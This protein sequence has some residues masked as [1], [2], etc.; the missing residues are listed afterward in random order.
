MD[1]IGVAIIGSGYW[2]INYVRSMSELPNIESVTVCEQRIDRLEEI[3]HKFPKAGLTT[4][5]DEVL[6][7]PDIGA[8]VICTPA[9]THYEV[10]RRCLTAG[11][12]VLVEKPIT[13]RSIDAEKL[14]GTAEE[15]DVTLMVGHTFIH[16]PAIRKLKTFLEEGDVGQPYYIYS[17]RTNMGPIRRDVNALWDLA[18]HDVS[19]FNYLLGAVPEWVSAVGARVLGNSNEDVG[20]VSIG[21]P[22]GMVGHIHV[23]W[24][25]PFKVR[26]IV[27]VGSD[28]RIV[29]DDL[30][31]LE[32]VK[33]Y[34]KGIRTTPEAS[35]YG[36]HQV[37]IRDGDIFSPRI[38]VS[39]PLKNQIAHFL[40]CVT[41]GRLPITSAWD[42]LNVVRVMEAIDRSIEQNGAPVEVGRRLQSVGIVAQPIGRENPSAG[43]A[44]AAI[45]LAGH[46]LEQSASNG[47]TGNAKE[48]A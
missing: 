43:L 29:F 8:V 44:S 10:A 45:D 38:E 7:R 32:R 42:G 36:E 18:P 27:V 23:S 4:D 15:Q 25:D 24:A 19:I 2:G 48:A 14:I 12:H 47:V 33:V 30:N 40:E 20:F 11:K 28:K 5:L 39:E 17:R 46:E 37:Q 6:E 1:R 3:G 26:E 21:Y 41:E 22:N 9:T 34:E 35:S 16:N 31:T 13:T